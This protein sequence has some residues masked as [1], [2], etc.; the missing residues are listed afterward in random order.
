MVSIIAKLTIFEEIHN[1]IKARKG[2][3]AFVIGVNGVDTSGK[4]M[5]AKSLSNYLFTN[6]YNTQLVHIDDFHNPNHI[7]KSG[8]NPIDSYYQNAFNI[9]L[10]CNEI[11]EPISK[12]KEIS[13]TLTLLDLESD[14]FTN[15]QEYHINKETIVIIEG[16]L[17]YREPLYRYFD[18]KIFLDISFNEVLRRAS[19]RD[20]PIYG[21]EFL[22]KYRNKYIPIQ[23]KYIAEHNPIIHSDIVIDNN[24]YY[25]PKIK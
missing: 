8:N 13:K 24:D 9:E 16:V 5:F 25:L 22:D 1:E 15:I 11:L 4:T 3:S 10:L 14:Q 21:E 18:L 12:G 19:L 20:V 17:L 7:R 23:K 6:G 2:M